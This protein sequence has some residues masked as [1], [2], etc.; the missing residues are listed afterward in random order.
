MIENPKEYISKLREKA[1][2]MATRSLA[3]TRRTVRSVC[4]YVRS[5]V[6][7][8]TVKERLMILFA[9]GLVIGFGVKTVATGSVTIGY[10][11]FALKTETK[12]YDLNEI[13]RRVAEKAL[14]G[15]SESDEP[16]TPSG[17]SC[18]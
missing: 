15:S 16:V 1:A 2:P 4:L 5:I 6:S 7:R 14:G 8:M 13:Q 10:Q 17:G 12:A 11:D 9:V 18:R 3:E